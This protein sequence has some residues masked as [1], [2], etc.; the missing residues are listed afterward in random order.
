M[1]MPVEETLLIEPIMTDPLLMEA[2][3]LIEPATEPI[4][5]PTDIY[6]VTPIDPVYVEPVEPVDAGLNEPDPAYPATDEPYEEPDPYYEE[7]YD[8]SSYGLNETSLPDRDPLYELI[9]VDDSEDIRIDEEPDPYRQYNCLITQSKPCPDIQKV[10]NGTLRTQIETAL[11]LFGGAI[12]GLVIW[13]VI[14]STMNQA[15]VKKPKKKR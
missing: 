12:L 3:T 2:L 15:R 11:I 13:V 7:P 5:E 1:I 14:Y 8:D 6:I 10:M 4:E 9:P